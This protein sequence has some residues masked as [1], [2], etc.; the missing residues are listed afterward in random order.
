M[1]PVLLSWITPGVWEAESHMQGP[2]PLAFTAPSYFTQ[3]SNMKCH[4]YAEE[5]VPKRKPSGNSLLFR[6][7][8]GSFCIEPVTEVTRCLPSTTLSTKNSETNNQ[9]AVTLL[10]AMSPANAHNLGPFECTPALFKDS[11][12]RHCHN[13]WWKLLTPTI[14]KRPT[15]SNRVLSNRREECLPLHKT[16]LPSRC[17]QYTL[18]LWATPRLTSNTF[19]HPFFKA[20]SLLCP[21]PPHYL[22]SYKNNVPLKSPRNT[23][24]PLAQQSHVPK[25]AGKLFNHPPCHCKAFSKLDLTSNFLLDLLGML[26]LYTNHKKSWNCRIPHAPTSFIT[27]PKEES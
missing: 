14:H 20:A 26:Q 7:C 24:P 25:C 19:Q 10:E 15:N 9:I 27:H 5:E 8:R 3:N 23:E 17:R 11:V 2:R 4:W 6:T 16:Q 22:V 1:S 13:S 18:T 21:L 12:P